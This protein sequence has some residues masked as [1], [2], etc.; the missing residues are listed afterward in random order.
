MFFDSIRI[1]VKNCCVRISGS[2]RCVTLRNHY[3]ISSLL[4]LSPKWVEPK[5]P[6]LPEKVRLL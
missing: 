2:G 5:A 3:I 4:G 1:F 6:E